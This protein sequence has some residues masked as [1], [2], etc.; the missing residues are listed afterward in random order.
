M[1]RLKSL[2]ALIPELLASGL[3]DAG[4]GSIAVRE[5]AGIYVTPTQASRQLRWKLTPD[6]FILFPGG[7]EASMS[8]GARQP[9]RE[10]RL[11]RS[12]LASRPDWNCTFLGTSWG[13][14]AYA[15]AEKPLLLPE[16]HAWPLYRSRSVE[17]P[18]LPS[19][20]E[21]PG[22]AAAELMNRHF[23]KSDL[24]A[25]IIGGSGPLITATE[26]N[27]VFSLAQTLENVARARLLAPR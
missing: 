10:N 5:N 21:S 17:I 13:L 6:D 8:R 11:H 12:M 25:V 15:L 16:A 2:L 3:L 22:E 4:G 7:G 24:G 9:S 20:S 26:V 18:I 1:E 19:G 14:L 23:I 27:D